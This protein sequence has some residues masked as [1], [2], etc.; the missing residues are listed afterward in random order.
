MKAKTKFIKLYYKLPEPS[1]KLI[2]Y[3]DEI[4]YTLNVIKLEVDANT[5]LGKIFIKEMGFEDD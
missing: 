5:E 2:W 4:P 3:L 1:R